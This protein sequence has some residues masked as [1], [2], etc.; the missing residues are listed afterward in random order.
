[1]KTKKVYTYDPNTLK[2]TGEWNCQPSPLEPGQFIVPEH[3]LDVPPP[4][5]EEGKEVYFNR[6]DG[7][8]VVT[9]PVPT[10]EEILE[11]KVEQYRLAVRKHMS[12]VAQSSPEK[13]NS[14][15]EAKSF[16]GTDNPLS[17][18]SKAF[19]IWAATVQVDANKKLAEALAGKGKLPE[20]EAFIDGL[21]KWKHPN[22]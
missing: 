1:M 8:T 21:P 16:V 17:A 12:K 2:P 10:D 9:T 4:N 5:A 20:L 11:V 6:V 15:S 3:C 7:W 18:V 13:F 19:Q 14:I 22:G